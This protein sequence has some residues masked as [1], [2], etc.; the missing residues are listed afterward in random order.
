MRNMAQRYLIKT[1][2][3][4]A[5]KQGPRKVI[6]VP[7]GSVIDVPLT[8]DGVRGL[9]EVTFSGETVL[10]FA[11]DIRNRGNPVSEASV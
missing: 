3:S 8:L 6:T 5:I 7:S 10:M 9:I 11:E 1:P 4:A 2:T